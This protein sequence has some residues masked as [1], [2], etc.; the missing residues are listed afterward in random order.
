[1]LR[2]VKDSDKSKVFLWRNLDKVRSVMFSN[3]KI[4]KEE[5]NNWWK[6]LFLDDTRQL[7]IYS[8][9][10]KEVGIVNFFKIDALSG[11][12]HWGFYFG[13]IFLSLSDRLRSWKDLEEEAIRYAFNNIGLRKLICETLASNFSVLDMHKRNGFLKT[14]EYNIKINNRSE[15]VVKMTLNRDKYCSLP[16]NRESYSVNGYRNS[17]EKITIALCG[18]SNLDFIKSD[19]KKFFKSYDIFVN[20]AL[21]PYNQYR[22]LLADPGSILQKQDIN[23]FI[24]IERID[25]LFNLKG[26]DEKNTINLWKEY[27][28]TL[29]HAKKN[30]RGDFMVASPTLFSYDIFS[31]LVKNEALK[32]KKIIKECHNYFQEKLLPIDGVSELDIAKIQRKIGIKYFH[33]GKYWYL[34]KIPFSS[35]ASKEV[36]NSIVGAW[37]SNYGLTS[38]L[39]IIDLDNTIWGGVIGDDGVSNISIGGDYPGNVFKDIQYCL[40][41]FI[42]K[43]F[44]LAVCSKNTE[45]I[46]IEAIEN[47]PEMVLNKSDFV[48]LRINWK[49]KYI[50][51]IDIINEIGI[52]LSAVCFID[53]NIVERNEVRS[54]LPDVKVPEMPVEISEWPSFINNLPELN[55]ETLTDEDKDRNKRYRNK[56]TMYNLEQKYKNR[57]DFLMS[58]NMKIS[59]S[60]LNSF[61]KQRVFQLVQKTNQFNTT[62]KRYTL[63]D[64]NNFLDD[65]DVWA[66][67]L[68]DS[69]NS[70]EIIST[71]FVRYISNDIII[72]NFVMSCRVLG[73]NLEVAILA[74]ISKYY[75]SKGVNNIE[76]RVVTTERNTPIHNLYENNGFI[77]E[78]ENKYKLN[79]NKS[80]LKI[81]NYFNIT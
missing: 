49:S 11:S 2:I 69:F 65:G 50:N 52:G 51:I 74:W 30:I 35:E 34:A 73:R 70:R 1:M 45:N 8:Y 4:T 63:Y 79:L 43:G 15:V 67:S 13:D 14:S 68:E 77:V 17:T 29:A 12:G 24:F 19:L 23:L 78:S 81:P 72:D 39:I 37:L 55:T 3:K 41:G 26:V 59:F 21:V 7:F 47:H 57:D 58:L 9:N 54:F 18:N 64:I 44:V 36:S 62:V 53:D 20:Y 22:M 27:I 38:K 46:A 75:G 71:L 32:S 28:D 66:I 40:K 42:K 80:D 33:P 10:N 16:N 60:S 5:H 48:S 25:E 6:S 61:N 31:S 56:N 76:A